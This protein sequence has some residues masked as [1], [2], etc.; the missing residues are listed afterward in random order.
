MSQIVLKPAYFGLMVLEGNL[1]FS[2][3]CLAGPT[4]LELATSGVTGRRSNQTEL[5]P[6]SGVLKL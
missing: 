1:G 6:R 2:G 3:K 4:R 5:R